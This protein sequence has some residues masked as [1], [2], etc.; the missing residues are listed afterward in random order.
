MF[1]R[2]YP[3]S[4]GGPPY[5]SDEPTP[6]KENEGDVTAEEIVSNLTKDKPGEVSAAVNV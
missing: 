4:C 2:N 5:S 6:T 1:E 3:M